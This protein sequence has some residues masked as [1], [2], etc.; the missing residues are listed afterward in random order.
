MTCVSMATYMQVQMPHRWHG[1]EA[2]LNTPLDA[3]AAARLRV[4]ERAIALHGGLAHACADV[5]HHLHKPCVRTRCSIA[6]KRPR[7]GR[8]YRLA[9]RASIDSISRVGTVTLFV[10]PCADVSSMTKGIRGRIRK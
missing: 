4:L 3:I 1:M 5:D 6:A 9:K 10:V 8:A 2:A 7:T